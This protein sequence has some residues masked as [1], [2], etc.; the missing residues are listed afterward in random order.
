M[1]TRRYAHEYHR[2]AKERPKVAKK[3]SSEG[4]SL[5]LYNLSLQGAITRSCFYFI[6]F[7]D[8]IT[9]CIH[10]NIIL[11]LLLQHSFDRV[12]NFQL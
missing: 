7:Y 10:M 9:H 1:N 4:M 3:I 5:V 11:A 6:Q 12:Y 8:Y 2:L